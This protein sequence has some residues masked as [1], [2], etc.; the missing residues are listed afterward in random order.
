MRAG[1]LRS[2]ARGRLTAAQDPIGGD[3]DR[4]VDGDLDGEPKEVD[5]LLD[6]PM[7]G[8]TDHVIRDVQ[9]LKGVDQQAIGDSPVLLGDR[10]MAVGSH[11][12]L[13]RQVNEDVVGA[14]R[15]LFRYRPVCINVLLKERFGG[16]ADY[17]FGRAVKQRR[18]GV[19][20]DAHSRLAVDPLMQDRAV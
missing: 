11:L 19:D 13:D 15:A 4:F 5:D 16:Q 17:S 3:G 10:P 14:L 7:H 8:S 6:A 2:R 20:P 9:L 18:A 1:G 12:E